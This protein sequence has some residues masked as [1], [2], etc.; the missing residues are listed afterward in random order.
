MPSCLDI[1]L[2]KL[3]QETQEN[4]M[5][6]LLIALLHM[7]LASRRKFKLNTLELLYGRPTSR[8]GEKEHLSPL[9]M[10]QLK[11]ALQVGETMRALTEYGSQ[12]LSA[13]IHLT[14]HPF[15]PGTWMHLKS[16]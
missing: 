1:A 10:E 8:T 5:K 4:W 9:E 14:L 13:P 16:W 12:V 11:C 6:L 3:C 7:Q 15:Q 2:A